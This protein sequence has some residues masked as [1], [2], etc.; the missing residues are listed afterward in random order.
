MLHF[1]TSGPPT[2]SYSTGS[3]P[4]PVPPSAATLGLVVYVVLPIVVVVSVSPDVP[5]IPSIIIGPNVCQESFDT[6][7]TD[8]LEPV[9]GLVS[10]H[11]TS[12]LL[13]PAATISAFCD[14]ASVELLRF[15]LSPNIC[16]PS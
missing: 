12:T 10:H 1:A 8:S 16:P 7:R 5:F 6:L 13:F 15:I 14:S 4:P 11:E 2:A 9:T 3:C